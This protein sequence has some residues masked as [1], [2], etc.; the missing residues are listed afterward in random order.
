MYYAYAIRKSSYKEREKITSSYQG[1]TICSFPYQE[2]AFMAEKVSSNRRPVLENL[3]LHEEI[4][5][6]I[7]R[8]SPSLP[9]Q[10]G[11]VLDDKDMMVEILSTFYLRL[12][13]AIEELNG[14]VELGVKIFWEPSAHKGSTMKSDLQKRE[15]KK[16]GEKKKALLYLERLREH[17]RKREE[18]KKNTLLL[19]ERIHK[20]LIPFAIK[21]NYRH[22]LN[23]K[24]LFQG[25]YLLKEEEI[26][27]FAKTIKDFERGDPPLQLILSGPWPPY[28]FCNLD[29]R[30]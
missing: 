24:C 4:V 5:E 11:V 6:K 30:R 18:D 13:S 9:V 3:L 15:E 29:L 23:E 1:H 17:H 25:S 28:S 19:T 26:T 27:C 21:G 2:L 12:M 10:F 14:L 8:E 7:W 20:S 22:L 16:N